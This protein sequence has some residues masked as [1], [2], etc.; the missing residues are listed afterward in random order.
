[1]PGQ[2]TLCKNWIP[3]GLMI[4]SCISLSKSRGETTIAPSSVGLLLC[5]SKQKDKNSGHGKKKNDIKYKR[6]N[7]INRI[8]YWEVSASCNNWLYVVAVRR[9][10]RQ[11]DNPEQRRK[12]PLLPPGKMQLHSE[13]CGLMSL[14]WAVLQPYLPPL[15]RGLVQ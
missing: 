2:L 6:V 4:Y 9:A 10:T 5:F 11:Y 13:A 1:M 14:V 15:P 3:R 8:E 7:G 12:V